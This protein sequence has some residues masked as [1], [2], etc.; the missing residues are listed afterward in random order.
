M[1]PVCL[2]VAREQG[3]MRRILWGF[4]AAKRTHRLRRLGFT[5]NRLGD[6]YDDRLQVVFVCQELVPIP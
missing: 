4:D 1:P 2:Q 6:V 3:F 5:L